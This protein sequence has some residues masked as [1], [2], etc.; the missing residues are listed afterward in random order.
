MLLIMEISHP[1]PYYFAR[2]LMQKVV[3]HANKIHWSTMINMKSLSRHLVF[4]TMKHD[5]AVNEKSTNVTLS[6]LLFPLFIMILFD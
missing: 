5:L 4:I 6:H 3:C 2:D 1:F